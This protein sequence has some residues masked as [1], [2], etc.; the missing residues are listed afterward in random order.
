[1]FVQGRERKAVKQAMNAI[2]GLPPVNN[3]TVQ[4]WIQVYRGRI[5]SE[6]VGNRK[7]HDRSCI[8]EQS[9]AA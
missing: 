4:C 3:S 9:L 1:M 5:V 8:A 7:L 6:Q 2:V